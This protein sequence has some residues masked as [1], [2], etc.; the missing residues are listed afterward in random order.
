M[1]DCG[2]GNH[3]SGPL[4]D[5]VFSLDCGASTF[6]D[7]SNVQSK[8][9]EISELHR[10]M[11][12]NAR[13][14][15]KADA[16]ASICERIS[17]EHNCI[18]YVLVEDV[19][20]QSPSSNLVY[21]CLRLHLLRKGAIPHIV[22]LSAIA[23]GSDFLS[24]DAAQSLHRSAITRFVFNVYDRLPVCVNRS[25]AEK[26]GPNAVSALMPDAFSVGGHVI[27]AFVAPAFHLASHSAPQ[28]SLQLHWPPPAL[29]VMDAHRLLHIAY[30][31]STDR[32]W[33]YLTAV[34]DKAEYNCLRV[35]FIE[36]LE[37]RVV[38]R[39]VWNFLKEA[40]E[41]ATV[42]WRICICRVGALY[43]EEIQGKAKSSVA[44][45]SCSCY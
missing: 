15:F 2:F 24:V 41:C 39:R 25:S 44:Y 8:L 43:A 6:R 1:Q 16:D 3:A 12:S 35:R 30:E 13:A 20:C 33:L 27:R 22:P 11:G 19:E 4:K 42:E 18:I 38:L 36:G 5:C 34:D 9:L 40:S 26:K 37:T 23:C 28:V 21:L 32:K 29:D 45:D 31:L 17:G 10:P 7:G 14:D